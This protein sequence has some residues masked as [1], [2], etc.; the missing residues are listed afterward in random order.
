V[1]LLQ[2]GSGSVLF[3]GK[4]VTGGGV[5]YGGNTWH[6]AQYS[7]IEFIYNPFLKSSLSLGLGEMG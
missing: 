1:A 7:L 4:M 5:L 2:L 3:V 6:V